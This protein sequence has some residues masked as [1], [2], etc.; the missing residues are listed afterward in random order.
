MRFSRHLSASPP[1][2]I[3]LSSFRFVGPLGSITVKCK[4]LRV[5]QLDVPGM[6][7]CLNIASSIEVCFIFHIS[8]SDFL[9]S[10][11]LMLLCAVT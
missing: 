11:L 2:N 3:F 1:F 7:E 9:N 5:I 6:E 8:L 4:D 10:T